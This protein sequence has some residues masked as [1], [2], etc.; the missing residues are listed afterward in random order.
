MNW[1]LEKRMPS[2]RHS[3]SRTQRTN[4]YIDPTDAETAELMK[5]IDDLEEVDEETALRM[6][7]EKAKKIAKAPAK[8]S[9]VDTE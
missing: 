8:K 4:Q 9:L 2:P 7:G 1:R 3:S 5:A 6:A